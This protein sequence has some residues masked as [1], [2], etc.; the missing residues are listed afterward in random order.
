MYFNTCP[1]YSTL[2]SVTFISTT[3]NALYSK[4]NNKKSI[5]NTSLIEV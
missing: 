5:E 1:I 3:T 2:Y 4:L